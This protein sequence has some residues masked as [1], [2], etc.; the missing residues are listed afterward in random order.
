MELD[1]FPAKFC[2]KCG[3]EIAAH[4]DPYILRN[5]PGCGYRAINS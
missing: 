4:L 5:C 1:Y 3:I 2:S